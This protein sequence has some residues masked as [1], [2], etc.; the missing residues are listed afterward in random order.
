M[1]RQALA[2]TTGIT[3]GEH[4]SSSCSGTDRSGLTVT[5]IRLYY[6]EIFAYTICCRTNKALNLRS[7]FVFSV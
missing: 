4:L 5:C 1:P 7:I 6:D 2:L 3:V